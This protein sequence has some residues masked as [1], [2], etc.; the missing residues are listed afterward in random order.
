MSYYISNPSIFS[1]IRYFTPSSISPAFIMNSAGTY[2]S[3]DNNVINFDSDMP[4]GLVYIGQESPEGY[5][6]G[7][8]NCGSPRVD[9]PNS[10]GT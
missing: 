2:V 1:W 5:T 6:A 8:R 3:D 7:G 9:I 4:S 10:H